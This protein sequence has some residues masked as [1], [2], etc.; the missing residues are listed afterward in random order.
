MYD[1]TFFVVVIT[2]VLHMIDGIIIDTFAD[3]RA[4]R[5]K[6]I[7]ITLF[8]NLKNPKGKSMKKSA[9]TPASSVASIVLPLST[10]R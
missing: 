9:K 7:F 10:N 1:L 6:Q 3:L 5:Y 2:I 4:E 8:L